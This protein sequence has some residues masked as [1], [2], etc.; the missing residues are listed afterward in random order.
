MILKKKYLNLFIVLILISC[1]KSKTEANLFKNINWIPFEWKESYVGKDTLKYGS[2]E[3]LTTIKGID[4]KL[5]MQFDLG[6]TNSVIY[7]NPLK[8]IIKDSLQYPFKVNW[9]D[10]EKFAGIESYKIKDLD[11]SSNT[12]RFQNL[13]PSLLKNYGSTKKSDVPH[14]GTIG[15]DVFENKYVIIDYN[16]K[17][18]GIT[19]SLSVRLLKKISFTNFEKTDIEQTVFKIKIDN[20]NHNVLFD[21]GSSSWTIITGESK[22][23]EVLGNTEIK[24]DSVEVSSWGKKDYFYKTTLNKT[25]TIAGKEFKNME[26][27]FFKDN[28]TSKYLYDNN[29]LAIIGNRIFIENKNTIVI[30][31]KNK[32]FGIIK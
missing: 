16:S 27:Y 22:F 12:Y 20:I 6:A 17:R 4:Q 30:D 18:I 23:N 28:N 10:K 31:Y 19:D 7:E 21:T 13:A 29:I 2:I 8:S 32:R 25:V 9:S 11:I 24:L 1:G 26:G 3:I 15:L 14:I 5:G